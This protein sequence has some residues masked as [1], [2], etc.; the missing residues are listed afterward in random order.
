MPKKLILI[1]LATLLLAAILTLHLSPNKIPAALYPIKGIDVSHHQS[2]IDWDKVKGQ[3]IDFAF[4]KATEGSGYVDEDFLENWKGAEES[5]ILAG[6]YHF[7]SYDSPGAS[8]A[9]LYIRTVGKLSGHLRPV[10][11]VEFYGDKE[12]NPPPRDM[13]QR[14]LAD[15]LMALEEEYSVKPILYTTYKVYKLYIKDCFDEYPLWIR[16]VYYP[17]FDKDWEFWQYSDQGRLEGIGGGESYVD[18]NVFR[19]N[20]EAL[21]E[22]VVPQSKDKETKQG[23]MNP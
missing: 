9:D 8:Q 16:N 11:D 18:L 15:Y 7:F 14:E 4:I 12:G 21:Q 5:G 6:A 10:A 17:P 3:E 19:G 22:M 13:V 2:S 1:P 20:E 23:Q